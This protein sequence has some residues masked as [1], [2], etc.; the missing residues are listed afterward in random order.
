VAINQDKNNKKDLDGILRKLE[1]AYQ[2]SEKKYR[3][4]IDLIPLGIFEYDLKGKIRYCNPMGLEMMGYTEADVEKNLHVFSFM[5][6]DEMEVA[7]ER[8]M[9]LFQGDTME[10]EE[11]TA[12]RKNGNTFPVMLYSYPIIEDG[13]VTGVRGVSFDLSRSKKIEGQLQELLARYEVMLMA[14]PDLIFRFDKEG[15]FIDYHTNAPANMLIDPKDFIGKRILDVALPDA[16]RV[17]G[18]EKVNE[19]LKSG[20]IVVDEYEL[21]SPDGLRYYEARYIPIEGKEVLD[22]I[23]DITEKVRTE[24]ELKES[25]ERFKNLYNHIPLGMY[26]TTPD[27]EILLANPALLKL[28]GASSLE[29]IHEIGF[30]KLTENLGYD[31]RA[32]VEEI[33]KLGEVRGFESKVRLQDGGDL[34]LRE[35]ARKITDSSGQIFYEGSLEDITKQK[36]ADEV[37][38]FTQFSVE[39]TADAAFWM[40]KDAKFFYVNERACSSLGYTKEE[41]LTM[42]VHDIDPV[43]HAGLWEN[44]WNDIRDRKYYSIESIHRTK[45]GKEFPVELQINY[46]KFDGVE[47]NCAF[48]RDITNRKQ[49][50]ESLKKAKEKAEEANRIKSEFISNIS[51]EIRTPL[52]SIIGFSDMLSSHLEE[53]KFIDYASSIKAAGNSLLMLIN[54][55]LDLSKIEAGRMEISPEAFDIR[56]IIKEVSQIFAVKVARKELDFIVDV[57]ESVPEILMLD[58]I[59]IRQVLFNLIGN[60]VKFTKHGFIRLVVNIIEDSAVSDRIGLSIRVEDSGVGISAKYV[61]PIFTPFYQVSGQDKIVKEGTGLGLSITKRL[62]E[63]MSGTIRV[64]SQEGQGSSF[65]VTMKDVAIAEEALSGD[66]RKKIWLTVLYGKHVL[67]VDDSDINRR[68]VKDNLED[69]GIIV[70]EAANGEEGLEKAITIIPDIILL[71]IMMPVMDGYELMEKI[72]LSNVLKDIPVMALTALAMKDDIDRIT[73]CGFDDILIKP[74]HI[75]ELYEKMIDLVKRESDI[76]LSPEYEGRDASGQDDL[77]YMKAVETAL[78]EIEKK[79]LSL[80]VQANELKDFNAI[81]AF[82]DGIQGTGK[83]SGIRFLVDYGDKLIVHCDNYDIEKID[84]SLA[85]FPEYLK[86]MREISQKEY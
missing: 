2:D 57:H 6:P 18:F 26:R 53:E 35:N 54:D 61:D 7:R 46:L 69:S 1:T 63:M 68:F 41:L 71:D 70:S 44:H 64:E 43:F 76:T 13:N 58:T 84:M 19:A 9:A 48:A 4:L 60:A 12:V 66:P 51:H 67:L 72:K 75:E 24:N 50:E 52:N 47:Y 37:L 25:R 27:N 14:L 86:K 23:R 78:I 21:E 80:W 17:R 74:F 45:T 3:E 32:F 31:R 33:E 65:I 38:K 81:R 77:K 15:R 30:D 11:Y 36:K 22:I 62:V 16:I 29:E 49:N 39:H 83:S 20:E 73:T 55:I 79:Y 34:Y 82:A 10:G 5:H 56:A 40:T 28:F 85:A 8:M 42:T 59:R